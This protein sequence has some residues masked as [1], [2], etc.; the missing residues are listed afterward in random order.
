MRGNWNL[1]YFC[2]IVHRL[3]SEWLWICIVTVKILKSSISESLRNEHKYHHRMFRCL[4]TWPYLRQWLPT[5]HPLECHS[6]E[7]VLHGLLFGG[8]SQSPYQPQI[9]SLLAL[10]LVDL[11]AKGDGELSIQG[12][13]TSSVSCH[14]IYRKHG[15]FYQTYMWPKWPLWYCLLHSSKYTLQT[16]Q[17]VKA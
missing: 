4:S 12:S 11:I 6:D 5:R 14:S 17:Q 13:V 7:T 1:Q 15:P 3:M 8:S 9:W 16:L 10:G 2:R